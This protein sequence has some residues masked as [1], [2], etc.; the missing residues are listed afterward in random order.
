MPFRPSGAPRLLTQKWVLLCSVLVPCVTASALNAVA[1]PS[2]E[3]ARHYPANIF[4]QGQAIRLDLTFRDLPT[5]DLV[6]DQ[7]VVDYWGQTVWQDTRP[8]GD[9]QADSSELSSKPDVSDPGYYE[10]HIA[11]R[12]PQQETPLAQATVSFGIVPLVDRSAREFREQGRKFGL[13]MY[14]LGKAHWANGKDEFDEKELVTAFTRMGLQWTR[15]EFNRTSHLPVTELIDQFPINVVLK[16]E[17]FPKTMFDTDRYG[18][19]EEWIERYGSA[20]TLKTVP[21]KEPYQEWVAQ[22]IGQFPEDQNVFE[23]WNEP[24]NKMSP[25][26]FAEICGYVVE[27]VQKVR[28]NAIIGPNLGGWTSD[29]E[30]DARFIEA[31]GMKGMNMV[32]LHPYG[33]SGDRQWL[34]N[35]MDWLEEKTGISDLQLHIT[36]YGTHSTPQGPAQRSEREQAQIVVNQS[37]NLYAAGADS[38]EPH[39]LGQREE[40]PTYHEH[41]FGFFRLNSQPKPVVVAHATTARMIDASTYLGDVWLGPE[42]DAMVFRRDGVDTLVLQTRGTRR[43]VDIDVDADEL[44]VVDMV[45]RASSLP[46]ESGR[47]RVEVGP[48]ALYLV[49]IGQS[50]SAQATRE[51]DPRRWPKAESAPEIQRSAPRLDGF[52]A[53]GELEEWADATTVLSMLNPK[54]AGDDASG[55]SYIAWDHENLYIAIDLRDNEVYNTQAR[56]KLYTH[57]SAE[58]FVSLQ[59]RDDNPGFGPR[60]FQFFLTPTSGEGTPIFGYVADREAGE[61]VDVP[62]AEFYAGP[63]RLG[64]VA[65]AAIPW[66]VLGVEEA[67]PGLRMA[68]ELRINDADQSHER[69]KIDAEDQSGFSPSDPVSWSRL[70]LIETAEDDSP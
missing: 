20:W 3:I 27:V 69:F 7:R 16:V 36:E 67:R 23:V 45:G 19:L 48:D 29:Y 54:V 53:D 60:D 8:I 31:G 55:A 59:P 40:T 30:F 63:S 57:D 56:P 68:Y 11:V 64:W 33:K 44:T 66:K 6:V 51:I 35:Y 1:A 43:E 10:L 34:L 12:D 17:R 58:I 28:P 15:T 26:D 49:G 65:E 52:R 14:Y 32:A 42:L 22:V 2:I 41:Y 46:T 61:V 21:K 18:P 47:A 13:K 39:W 9:L 37:L 70:E 50:L 5:Q 25:E 24:W 4:D 62:G 38:L